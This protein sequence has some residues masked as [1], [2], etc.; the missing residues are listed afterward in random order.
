M[1]QETKVISKKL[2]LEKFIP[3]PTLTIKTSKGFFYRL[4]F[5]LVAPIIWLIKGEINIR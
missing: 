5:L 1:T 2:L 3:P 4:F